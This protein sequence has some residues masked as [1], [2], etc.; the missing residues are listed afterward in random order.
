[1]APQSESSVH[2]PILVQSRCMYTGCHRTTSSSLSSQNENFDQG[3]S[4]AEPQ[5]CMGDT[6]F[7]GRKKAANI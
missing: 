5:L 3:F 2:S 4:Q 6:D 7:R 1:M